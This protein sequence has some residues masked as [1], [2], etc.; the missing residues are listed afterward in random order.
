MM[1]SLLLN[2]AAVAEAELEAFIAEFNVAPVPSRQ[3]MRAGCV[4]WIATFLPEA[5]GVRLRHRLNAFLQSVQEHDDFSVRGWF[6]VP[7]LA[8]AGFAL[9]GIEGELAPTVANVDHHSSSLRS[10]VLESLAFVAPRLTFG[11]GELRMRVES[12]LRK[13]HLF[14]DWSVAVLLATRGNPD[15]KRT[16]A[17]AW[18]AQNL[19]PLERDLLQ[20]AARPAS[21]LQNPLCASLMELERYTLLRL[22]TTASAEERA[23]TRGR[24]PALP[25]MESVEF[26]LLQRRLSEHPLMNPTFTIEGWEIPDLKKE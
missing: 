7:T 9:D 18:A 14:S 2:A 20:S 16:W 24:Q 1:N 3:E 12:N 25:G 15:D 21:Q 4:A 11:G 13:G 5:C 6:R 26:E 19:N 22:L 23:E 17:A 8:A 10:Y